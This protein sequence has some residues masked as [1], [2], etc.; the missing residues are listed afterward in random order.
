MFNSLFEFI[1]ISLLTVN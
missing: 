1:M